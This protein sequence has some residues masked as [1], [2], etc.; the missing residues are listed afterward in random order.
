MV[1]HKKTLSGSKEFTMGQIRFVTTLARPGIMEIARN[2]TAGI[3]KICFK[4]SFV[5]F[6]IVILLFSV[7]HIEHVFLKLFGKRR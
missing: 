6:M 5:D 2:A 1:I 4:L 3:M 7:F